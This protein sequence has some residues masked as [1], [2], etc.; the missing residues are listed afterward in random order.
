[1]NEFVFRAHAD[2]FKLVKPLKYISSID[3]N[4]SQSEYVF[5]DYKGYVFSCFIPSLILAH[6][7]SADEQIILIK[8]SIDSSIYF[9]NR[10]FFSPN[11]LNIDEKDLIDFVSVKILMDLKLIRSKD[12]Y[13]NISDFSFKTISDRFSFLLNQKADPLSAYIQ[14]LKEHNYS[15]IN[16]LEREFTIN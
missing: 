11:Y 7:K 2:K 13:N 15:T 10:Y 9:L 1:M 3:N 12:R 16:I 5:F 6:N 4:G 14:I 8:E